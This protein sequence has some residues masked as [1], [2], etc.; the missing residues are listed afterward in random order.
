[1]QEKFCHFSKLVVQ[2]LVPGGNPISGVGN[3]VQWDC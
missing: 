3:S 2:M 1:M